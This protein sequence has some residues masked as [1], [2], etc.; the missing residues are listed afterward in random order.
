MHVMNVRAQQLYKH[1]I[2]RSDASENY[3]DGVCSYVIVIFILPFFERRSK[4]D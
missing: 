1:A 3:S 4:V 2:I